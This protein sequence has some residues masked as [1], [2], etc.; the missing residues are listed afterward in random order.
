MPDDKGLARCKPDRAELRLISNVS[1]ARSIYIYRS[2]RRS[3][4]YDPLPHKAVMTPYPIKHS[5]LAGSSGSL[6]RAD[7]TAGLEEL[8]YQTGT[9]VQSTGADESEQ[10]PASPAEDSVRVYLSEM[11]SVP[12]LTKPGEIRLATRVE[13]G[14]LTLAKAL[15][16]TPWLWEKLTALNE[17]LK[18]DR[19]DLR[20][21]I[22]FEG[23]G[24]DAEARSRVI[25]RFRRRLAKVVRL[26]GEVE[27]LAEKAAARRTAGKAIRRRW[28]FRLARKKVELSRAIRKAALKYDARAR[29]A[30]EFEE[31]VPH[32]L[33]EAKAR[34][35]RIRRRQASKRR[36]AKAGAVRAEPATAMTSVQIRR[37][38]DR[39]RR[40]KA[41]A[42]RARSALVE[43]NLRLV[44]SVAKK[45]V[46]RGLHLLDLVQEGNMGL[47]R[48]A[49]KFDY[50]R[51]FKFSTYATW[52]IRQAVTRSLADQSRTVRVPVHMHEQLNKFLRAF[53][54][55]EKELN[56]PPTDQEIANYMETDVSKIETL[57][58]ISR[59]PVSLKTPVG[60]TGESSL[61]DLL[62]DPAGTSPDEGILVSDVRNKT[63][64]VLGTLSPSEEKVIRLRFGIGCEREH[65]LQEI[66][67]EF[68]VT[69]ERI[70]QIEAKAL[71]ALR[72]PQRAT[73]LRQLL[74]AANS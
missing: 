4:R 70:R 39:V 29:L 60:R 10:L 51:G 28:H 17:D 55:L 49:E 2:R 9:R 31:A 66:G 41:Q 1:V 13:R 65:T 74:L 14:N 52:W 22:D 59:T 19:A 47:M 48:A 11:G 63:A 62:E 21:W 5:H 38:R 23:S 54:G 15:S 68:A 16:Y 72:D 50:R 20:R 57:R 18:Q 73:Q 58:S 24:D 46:N 45:Y 7:R 8:E 36:R 40:G 32:L 69:R 35:A 26:I 27:E 42:D 37:A 56:R 25:A 61:E 33:R 53:R 64:D 12:L 44:V 34:Q 67:R 30:V 71:Q 43:A 6:A 3:A